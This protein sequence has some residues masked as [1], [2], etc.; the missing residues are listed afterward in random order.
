M[1]IVSIIRAKII[2]DAQDEFFCA[3]DREDAIGTLSTLY[4]GGWHEAEICMVTKR[5][6]KLE[7][8]IFDCEIGSDDEQRLLRKYYNKQT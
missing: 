7:E 5:D 1:K 8:K 6:K 3:Y 2:E 4:T